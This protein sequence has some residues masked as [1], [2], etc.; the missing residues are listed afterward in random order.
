MKVN[1]KGTLTVGLGEVDYTLHLGMSVI[2]DLQEKHGQDVL[3][4][5]QPPEGAGNNWVPNVRVVVD[6]VMCSLQRHHADVADQWLVD[7]I[8]AENQDIFE[9]LM[10]AAF[11]TPAS[12]AASAR[13][14]SGNGRKPRKAA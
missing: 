2:A 4:M 10:V 6:L 7:D 5:L 13:A 12:G 11:P 8:L 1:P 14:G 9:K 3:E